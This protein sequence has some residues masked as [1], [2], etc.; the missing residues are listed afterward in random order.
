MTKR[1]A[2]TIGVGLLALSE[3]AQAAYQWNL[4]T[5]VTQVA[6]QI[7]D[8]HLVMMGIIMVIFVGV[9]GVMFY[10]I[11]AHRRSVGHKAE[12]LSLIHISE[13]TRPY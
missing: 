2:E 8:L 11:Y 12:H 1:M 13:P 10:S 3:T 6:D 5:P 9:F 4:Q 7:Y